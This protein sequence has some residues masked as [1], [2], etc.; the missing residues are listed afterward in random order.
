MINL[1]MKNSENENLRMKKSENENLRI[2]K[3]ENENLRPTIIWPAK[4]KLVFVQSCCGLRSTKPEAENITHLQR[5][6][7][8]ESISLY[9]FILLRNTYYGRVQWCIDYSK[10]F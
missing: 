1:R 8:F 6:F 9:H 10:R 7:P 4:L 5:N 3:S 2:Q